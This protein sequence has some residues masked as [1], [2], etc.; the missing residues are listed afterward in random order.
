[1]ATSR[2]E[3]SLAGLA[4]YGF[5]ELEGTIAKLDELVSLVGDSGRSA[6]AAL[7]KSASPDQALEYLLRIARDNRVALKKILSKPDSALRLIRVLGTSAALSDFIIQNPTTLTLFEKELNKLPSRS[8]YT[9]DA[10]QAINSESDSFSEQVTKLRKQYRSQLLTLAI[11]DVNSTSPETVQPIISSALSD[12]ASAALEAGLVIARREMIQTTEH[13]VFTAEEV[14]KTKLAV[15]GMGKGGAG[16]LNYISDVDV[17]FVADAA[18]ESIETDRMLQVATKLATRMMRAMDSTNAEPALWQVDANLRPEGKAGALVRT[19]S[20]HVSYYSKWA[21]NW[22]FQALLKARP[23]AGDELLG[24][25]YFEQMN[26]LVWQSAKRDNFVESVQRMRERVSGNIPSDE[27]DRQIKLGP[28][29]LRDI[30]FTVQLLQLVHGRSDDSVRAPDTLTAIGQL[31]AVGYIG[32]VEATEFSNHYR[33]LRVLEHR[34]QMQQMRRTHL[35]PLDET[36]QRAIARSINLSW[37][38]QDLLDEWNSI[39]QQ[40]RSLH[41][42]LF[43][44]PLL[45]AVSKAT[46][47]LELSNEQA[48]DRLAA[49]GYLYPEGALQ[50]ISALTSGLSRRA[51]IQR[52]LLPVLLQWFSEGTDPDAALL[53]FRR[54]SENL[55]ESHWYLRMLRD[56]SG[57]AERL[58]IA[59]SNSRLATMLLELIPEGAAWFDDVAQ[60]RVQSI[61]SLVA[62]AEALSTRH[63][64]LD[65]YAKAMRHIRRRETLR[66]ALGAVVGELDISGVSQGL[67]ELTQFYLTTL[68]QKIVS[69]VSYQGH[70]LWELVDFGIVA[71][72]RF[73]GQELGFGSDADLIFVYSPRSNIAGDLAQKAAER[74]ISELHRVVTDPQLEFEIDMELRPEGRNGTVARSIDSYEAYYS[75]W[76]DIWENQA[77]LRARVIFGSDEL[78]LRFNGAI[79]K[80]RYPGQLDQKSVIEIRRIKAR[81]ENERLPQGADPKRHLKLGRGSL[82][83]IEWLVQL[84]QLKF[85]NQFPTIRTPQTLKAIEE[86]VKCQLLEPSDATVLS[87]A[88]TF[89]SRVRSAGVLWSNKRSDVL[90]TDRRQLEGIA[91]ILEYP[92]G[93]ASALEED[94][95]AQ[96]RRARMVFDRLFFA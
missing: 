14:E 57:A 16:E 58:S 81:M 50:H 1:M 26:P 23:M 48:I 88:W 18:D 4:K 6:L 29:G 38:A 20:S 13:G 91:R 87:Q 76:G 54:L 27:V 3:G 44:R 59:L 55:G 43:Y 35:M 19:L 67:S 82:S 7:E 24:L 70:I 89:V 34:I 71:M 51:Q 93:S 45:V 79:D 32:R 8:E 86:L 33:F 22:E 53:A 66:L 92:R 49:I 37:N 72:G 75:R 42:R 17:I 39:K 15:I 56:S 52:Q 25:K 5:V 30:E 90:P 41:Q 68:T 28:G 83:D 12:L 74:L 85:G 2:S 61:E 77:L 65:D 73:G 78:M 95:L 40:V 21:E 94:Y 60:L 11:R 31:S 10:L 47:G 69:E 96:T 46:D 62:Q 63:P 84:L 80:Y 9:R 64:E 36:A